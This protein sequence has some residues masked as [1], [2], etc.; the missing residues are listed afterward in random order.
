MK[1]I[2]IY[3]LSGVMLLS[4]QN[5]VAAQHKTPFTATT[6]PSF[7]VTNGT[8]VASI[9][10]FNCSV[11]GNKVMLNWSVTANQAA[12]QFM[13]EKSTDG[14][15]FVMAALVFGTDKS[16]TDSYMFYEKQ[17]KAKVSYRIKLVNKDQTIVYSNIIKT[18]TP[19]KK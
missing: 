12:D 9:T 3:C 4:H 15:N 6:T 16:D 7:S 11:T 14:K 13:I 19:V 5:L 10:S 8:P 1:K 2:I 17:S 18:A